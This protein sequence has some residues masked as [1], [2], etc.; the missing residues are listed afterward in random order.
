MGQATGT[1]QVADRAIDAADAH[2]QR[3]RRL[4][5]ENMHRCA[6]SGGQAWRESDAEL[7]AIKPAV[8]ARS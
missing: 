2:R 7:E 5:V 6:A 4:S 3:T 8:E 1:A